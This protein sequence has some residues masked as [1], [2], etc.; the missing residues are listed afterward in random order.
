MTDDVRPATDEEIV[1]L[2]RLADETLPG[3]WK[4]DCWYVVAEVPDGRPGGEVVA[5][6]IETRPRRTRREH[7][8]AYI[9]AAN[10]TAMASILARLAAERQRADAAEAA[11]ERNIEVHAERDL[12]LT[13]AEAE[14]AALRAEVERLTTDQGDWRKGVALIASAL[15]EHEPPDLCCVRI[16]ELALGQR[17]AL[18]QA[19]ADR[20]AA[21]AELAE[22]QRKL[23]ALCEAVSRARRLL[24]AYRPENPHFVGSELGAALAA[25]QGEKE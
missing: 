12:R 20:D 7:M 11:L 17:A 24:C 6:C 3:P 23:A 4:Q 5:Q 2:G 14:T 25:A 15:G 21:R 1:E 8:A 18:E 9:A 10:P 22:T 13:D 19:E 16:A